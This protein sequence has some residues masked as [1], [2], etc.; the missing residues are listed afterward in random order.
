MQAVRRGIEADVESG[1]SVVDQLLNL[2]LVRQ[3]GQQPSSGRSDLRTM[4]TKETIDH[5]CE[6]FKKQMSRF[7][8]FGDRLEEGSSKALMVNNASSCLRNSEAK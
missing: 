1:L 6:C 2:F 8:E 4:M 3:L 5:N 7:I